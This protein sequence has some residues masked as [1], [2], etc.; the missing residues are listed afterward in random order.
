MK[1]NLFIA[2]EGIDGSGKSTQVKLLAQKLTEAGHKVYITFEPT[3]SYIGTIIR[4]I[5]KGEIKAD[6][7]TIAG[8][9]VADRLNHLLNDT[10]GIVK[11]INDGYTVIT[12]R[13]YFSSYAYHSVHMDMEWVIQA[14][15]MSAEILRPDVN[16]YIDIS[17][18]ISMKRLHKNRE[19][20]ELYEN[21]ENLRA[22]REKYLHAFE[23]LAQEENIF[24][25]NGNR[26]LENIA[27]DI[28][29]HISQYS[30]GKI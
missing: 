6:N 5:M 19:T 9:F 14:N 7:K 17:A 25:V 28:W 20:I 4:Q 10:N 21:L 15:A 2:F 12:D 3:D 23:K 16:I 11:K 1:N 30:D 8:L 29:K 18:E 27:D 26:A 22:V 24:T 13:Y